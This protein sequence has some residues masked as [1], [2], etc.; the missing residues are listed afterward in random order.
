MRLRTSLFLLALACGAVLATA[1]SRAQPPP[2]EQALATVGPDSFLVE[3]VTTRGRFVVKAR[4]PWSPLG[5]DRLHH[6]ARA[7]Y[8]DG[9]VICRVGPTASYEGGFVVQFGIGNDSTVNAVFEHWDSVSTRGRAYLDRAYPGLDRID[10]ARVVRTWPA[11][12][13]EDSP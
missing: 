12:T 3:F 6:L 8:Y 2:A 7:R 11:P 1:A 5:A 13:P 4:R 9:V 10:S